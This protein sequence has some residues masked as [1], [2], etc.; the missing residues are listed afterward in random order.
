MSKKIFALPILCMFFI[1]FLTTSCIGD[2]DDYEIDEEWKALNENRFSEAEAEG[3]YQRR[4]SQT[5]DGYILWKKSS[6]I[7][8][9]DIDVKSSA[10][11]D[12]RVLFT[13]SVSY[14]CI[15]WYFD[16]EGEKITFE[17]TEDNNAVV[18]GMG[19]ARVPEGWRTALY[20]MKEGDEVE[21]VIP[22]QLGYGYTGGSINN[23]TI[24]G[25]TT[26]WFNIKLVKIFKLGKF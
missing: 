15:G 23:I 3:S 5:Q 24:P 11:D 26:L 14:R 4:N 8:D 22:Y 1:L 2:D 21:I 19:V 20:Y 13:D 7:S 25:F 17:S 6:V 10:N 12:D 18:K 16:K 9:N